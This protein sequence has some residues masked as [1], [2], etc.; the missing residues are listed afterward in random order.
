VARDCKKFS[1]AARQVFEKI[2]PYFPPD[3]WGNPKWTKG[4]KVYDNGW[5]VTCAKAMTVNV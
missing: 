5:Y 2:K 3:P 1:P 4:G